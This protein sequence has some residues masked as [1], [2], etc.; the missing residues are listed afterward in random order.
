MSS[1][2]NLNEKITS[3][4]ENVC[5][6]MRNIKARESVSREIRDHIE[7]QTEAYI[8]SGIGK[9][10]AVG[11]ALR[12]MGDPED[13]GVALDLIHRPKL[14]WSAIS[15]IAA[16]T[17]VGIAVQ[18]F[19]YKKAMYVHNIYFEDYV[20]N[21]IVGLIVCI[22]AYRVG[23]E[24]LIKNGHK[25]FGI[26]SILFITLA[27]LMRVGAVD[28]FQWSSK[29]NIFTISSTAMLAFVPLY[30]VVVYTFR[31][32]GCRGILCCLLYCLLPLIALSLTSASRTAAFIY[33]LCCLIILAAAILKGTFRVN[34]IAATSVVCIVA[35]V[36]SALLIPMLSNQSIRPVVGID[37]DKFQSDEDYWPN[38]LKNTMADSKPFGDSSSK[39]AVLKADEMGID[40]Y[41]D[42][43]IVFLCVKI[44]Y[45]PLCIMLSL[46]IMLF[47]SCFVL[48]VR[49]KGKC[50]FLIS[51]ACIIVLILQGFMY[52]ICNFGVLI[53]YLYPLPYI[54]RGGSA[55]VVDMVM[56]GFMLSIFANG[57]TTREKPINKST[58]TEIISF[59]DKI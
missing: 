28:S 58:G 40:F 11:M 2:D 43:L 14:N 35:V 41:T 22:I 59:V 57:Y 27:V 5:H 39:L 45:I 24:Q 34:I 25:F 16:I 53:D 44:G 20:V 50:S 26:F 52:V 36:V 32:L 15:L 49:Q 29:L 38:L 51:F 3:Y 4:V 18:Y 21:S 55:Y 33:T 31:D 19:V 17:I 37:I 7:D 30:A 12:E 48:S 54:S 47:V 1:L 9:D 13:V 6:R 46:I 42:Y 10:E 56:L 23:Y 8:R